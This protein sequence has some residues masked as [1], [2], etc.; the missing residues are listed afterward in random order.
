M[1]V[2]TAPAGIEPGQLASP[3]LVG[4]ETEFDQLLEAVTGPPAVV[5]V[6]GE[7]GV[8]KTRLVAEVLLAPELRGRRTLIGSCQPFREPLPFGPV[9]EAL[10]G[11][12]GKRFAHE[13]GAIA[14]ALRPL[15]PELGEQLPPALEALGDQRSERHRLFRAIVEVFRA[16]GPAI[17]VL[18][19]LHWSD[20]G[21][22]DLVRFLISR[23]P[24]E[25]C[26][27]LTL[28]REELPASSAVHGL[29]SRLP[30][31]V[32]R[33]RVTLA[34]LSRTE[35]RALVKSMLQLE[36]VSVEFADY[37]HERTLG[38]PFAVEEVLGLL[39]DRRD[40]VR[41]DGRWARRTLDRLEVPDA[42]RDSILE[43]LARLSPDARQVT[44]AA[45][46]VGVASDEQLLRQVAGLPAERAVRGLS[47]ALSLALLRETPG[48]LADF[49]H[50]LARQAVYEAIAAP[51]RRRLH[52]RAARRLERER[53]PIPL[54][55]VAHHF[56][57]AGAQRKWLHY[58]EG[59]SDLALSLGNAPAASELLA[60]ALS[61]A[62]TPAAARGRLAVKLGRAALGSLDHARALAVL[63]SVLDEQTLPPGV[64]G[65]VRLYVGLLLDN[66]AG[67]A[68]AGFAEIARA[69]PE[70][71]RRPGLA[72][73]AM[74]VLAVPM[75]AEGHVSEHL[76]WMRRALEAA[77]RVDDP[78]LR[79]G[80]LVNRATTLMHVGDPDAWRA[81]FDLPDQGAS[82]GERRQLLRASGN[83]AHACTCIGHYARADSF[84]TR[85]VGLAADASDPYLA[86]SLDSTRVLLDWATGRWSG[87]EARARKLS[88]DTED[89]PRVFAE[90]DLVLGQILLSRGEL[91]EAR[92]HLRAAR[93]LALTSGS[94][95][96]VAIASG[97]LA[98][99]AFA[100]GDASRAA[101]QALAGLELVRRKGIWV[102][103]AE[104]APVAVEA[105][106]A[107][108][109]RDEA[110]ELVDELARGLR[111]RDAPAGRA[112]LT[113]CRAHL[114]LGDG[115]PERAAN[116]FARAERAWLALPRP[117]EVA[118]CREARGLAQLASGR[119]RTDVLTEALERFKA[120][121]ASWD[122]ARVRRSLRE[123]G[124][125]RP[126]RGGRRG[127]GKRLSPREQ[128]VAR[129]AAL[130]RTNREI[131]EVLVLSPRTVE[132]H[133]AKAMRKLGVRSRTAL[134]RADHA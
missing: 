58:A 92:R 25:L 45:A 109:R 101:D 112:A 126:W 106:L 75:A 43:R 100:R 115:R 134:S 89:I 96:I 8:G 116:G 88:H 83:L 9:I 81:I 63:R 49:R 44:R 3:A 56:K 30:P 14:G 32:A 78:V 36:D 99:M 119:E 55:L 39:A 105:L 65:E 114:A 64:R 23:L 95:P 111:A 5:V 93:E 69:V 102:W 82:A 68:S 74:S 46:V 35:V 103:G 107:D 22:G 26:L 67:Q 2:E 70:L 87:L 121:G 47:Q 122:A 127:Y 16:L 128:E 12:E 51:Q 129:Q 41:K 54:A 97:G 13:P 27:V 72:A 117:Y 130:G 31:D 28:R 62:E 98:R 6:E 15:L 91:L 132:A 4:R 61:S 7:A 86:L 29:A 79:T 20:E 66:H 10:R 60:D 18:E 19:D 76:G 40:L 33:A 77:A 34:P 37:L 59:A 120:L 123:H 84:L 125:L 57:Q 24:E 94:I 48:G 50:A 131:A 21:T 73:Q 71:R 124:V 118:R 11:A 104:L 53:D 113:V 110:A 90:A 108:G 52:L 133:L 85:A 17:C 1:H 80:V 38:L 42:V